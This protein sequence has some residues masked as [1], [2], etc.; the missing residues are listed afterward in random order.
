MKRRGYTP[1]GGGA[2]G[3]ETAASSSSSIGNILLLITTIAFGLA[4]L[5]ICIY[6]AVTGGGSSNCSTVKSLPASGP[7]CSQGAA[8][9]EL[10]YQVRTD[11]AAIQY[12][13]G[14]PCHFSNGDE[15]RY[16]RLSF[17]CDFLL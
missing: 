7:I 9:H 6:L 12:G 1:I 14:A 15:Q 8:R 11:A 17:F 5:A 2:K 16:R 13:R 3:E 4:L 10:A